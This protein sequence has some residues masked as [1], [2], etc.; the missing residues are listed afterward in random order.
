M[1]FV[2]LLEQPST[3]QC[4][5]VVAVSVLE[6]S[7]L[8]PY[9]GFLSDGSLPTNVKVAEKVRRTLACFWLSEDKNLYRRSFA[10]LY[11]LCLHP[12]KTVEL[13]GRICR[14]HSRGRSL[15]H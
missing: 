5:V 6:P 12:R 14:G 1:I 8:D 11:L 2:K 13:H 7:W 15:A 9:L 10:G 4:A 3:E